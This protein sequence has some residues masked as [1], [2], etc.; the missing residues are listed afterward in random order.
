VQIQELKDFFGM[1]ELESILLIQ[2]SKC[3][4]VNYKTEASCEKAY[5]LFNGES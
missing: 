5:T 4:F 1:D 2:K 3:A